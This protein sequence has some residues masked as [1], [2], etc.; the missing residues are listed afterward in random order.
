VTGQHGDGRVVEQTHTQLAVQHGVEHGP[1]GHLAPGDQVG[2]ELIAVDAERVQVGGPVADG[3]L[4]FRRYHLPKHLVV[5][6]A[7]DGVVHR[8]LVEGETTAYHGVGRL[9]GPDQRA[10]EDVLHAVR[11][12]GPVV[13]FTLVLGLAPAGDGDVVVGALVGV[14]V[15]IQLLDHQ[16]DLLLVCQSTP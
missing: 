10:D 11:T 7:G 3:V 2:D 9:R 6:E 13:A 8:G 16:G 14:A 4:E 15:K 12:V 1:D 5:A